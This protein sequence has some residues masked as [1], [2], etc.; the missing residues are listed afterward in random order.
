VVV[1]VRLLSVSD[2]SQYHS[3]T[4]VASGQ[5]TR[6]ALNG[7]EITVKLRTKMVGAVG[8]ESSVKRIFNNMQVSG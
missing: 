2:K 1:R 8:F 4:G 5:V 6:L 3:L 7:A